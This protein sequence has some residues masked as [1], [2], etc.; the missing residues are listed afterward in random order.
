MAD[1]T[2]PSR[3]I[4]ER[5]TQL[6]DWRG[7]KLAALREVILEA[8]PQIVEEWK[9]VKKTSRERPSGPGRGDLYGGGL[10]ERG[11]ADLLQGC[12]AARPFRAVQ[13]QPGRKHPASN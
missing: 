8:D 5:I 2:E 1:E 12:C 3:L 6:A 7:Q 10:Q 9:W 4:D 13:L 11:E